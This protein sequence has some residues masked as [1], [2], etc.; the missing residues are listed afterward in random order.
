MSKAKTTTEAA[1]GP[2]AEIAVLERLSQPAA[3]WLAGVSPRTLRDHPEIRRAPDG[4]YDARD[5]LAF[6]RGP[7]R[8]PELNDDQIEKLLTI[9]ERIPTEPIA[10]NRAAIEALVEDIGGDEQM[11]L[12]AVGLA[13][14]H[15][16]LDCIGAYPEGYDYGPADFRQAVVC[17]T[18]KRLRH[19]TRWY[20]A[21]P[22]R[23]YSVMG[24]YCPKCRRGFRLRPESSDQ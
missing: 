24:A 4:S 19:G 10:L 13:L 20:E 18:C 14:W 16:L 21:D 7:G 9:A 5:V 1:R 17:L 15:E 3:A 2:A 8:L 22:P 12:A 6:A 23:G 11:A